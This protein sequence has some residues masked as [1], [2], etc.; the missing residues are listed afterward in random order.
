[1]V[2]RIK[3]QIAL[4]IMK[5]HWTTD[6]MKTHMIEKLDAMKE[7]VGYPEWYSDEENV[8]TIYED[9]EI[10][11]DFFLNIMNYGRFSVMIR[12]IQFFEPI[13]D[14]AWLEYPTTRNAFYS[15]LDNVIIIPAAELQA[16][17][18]SPGLPDA[19]NYGRIGFLIGHE[20][21]H[22]FDHTGINYDKHGNKVTKKVQELL[23]I[24][25]S[26]A[27]CFVE[28]FN[29]FTLNHTDENGNLILLNGNL[30]E[31]ENIADSTGIKIAYLAYK[32]KAKESSYMSLPNLNHFN[33]DQ[34]FFLSFATSW[35]SVL[36]PIYEKSSLNLDVHS[37]S[38]FR[39]VG[40][41]QNMQ[42]FA[43]AFDCSVGTPMNPKKKCT[44]WG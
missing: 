29:A 18:F 41:L 21:S 38:N 4:G 3:K 42:S 9:L 14:D 12:A 37:P 17:Y 25:N 6:S 23:D 10:G 8:D 40:S 15:E 33:Q 43:S 11:D 20:L 7:Q 5:T 44:I 19:V 24:Y 32:E 2:D 34:L 27:K 35:C 1:M 39:I 22:G 13:S 31:N 28:Q 30:T 16:P 26:K 36:H